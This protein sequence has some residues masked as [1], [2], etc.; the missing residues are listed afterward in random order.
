MESI[1]LRPREYIRDNHFYWPRVLA[2]LLLLLYLAALFLASLFTWAARDALEKEL[3]AAREAHGLVLEQQGTVEERL[4]RLALLQ[5]KEQELAQGLGSQKKWQ[6]CLSLILNQAVGRVQVKSFKGRHT[7]EISVEVR[8][9][10]LSRVA[11]Y[12]FSLQERQDFSRLYYK[13]IERG[14]GESYLVHLEG[15]VSFP[16]ELS[17]SEN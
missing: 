12:L 3:M 11:E 6:P 14:R 10:E 16:G 5:E 2:T 7:G 15:V 1:D 9:Q 8:A 13:N 17:L 4:N